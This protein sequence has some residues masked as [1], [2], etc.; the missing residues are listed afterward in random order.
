[1]KIIKCIFTTSKSNLISRNEFNIHTCISER[2]ESIVIITNASTYPR[3]SNKPRTLKLPTVF[4]GPPL[5][6]VQVGT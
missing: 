5:A 6:Q 2:D 3:L 1:M 4:Q